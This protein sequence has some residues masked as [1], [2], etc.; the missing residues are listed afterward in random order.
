M[1]LVSVTSQTKSKQRRSRQERMSSCKSKRECD[2]S[3]G[4]A[5]SANSKEAGKKTVPMKTFLSRCE[6]IEESKNKIYQQPKQVKQKRFNQLS[7]S[8]LNHQLK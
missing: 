2:E 3:E 7:S 6:G 4:F 1:D 5:T 8:H